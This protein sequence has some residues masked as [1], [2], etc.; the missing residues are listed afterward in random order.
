M[1]TATIP[2]W[3][4]VVSSIAILGVINVEENDVVYCFPQIGAGGGL[5][6]ACDCDE[7]G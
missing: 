7:Y 3:C 6:D 2:L 1:P 5:A 4:V